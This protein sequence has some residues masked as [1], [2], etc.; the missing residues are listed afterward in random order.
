MAQRWQSPSGENIT[1]PDGF[2][3][4]GWQ[5]IGSSSAV[6]PS[7]YSDGLELWENARTGARTI[8][9]EGIESIFGKD[10][11]RI[12]PFGAPS[13]SGVK[14]PAAPTAAQPTSA[15][16]AGSLPPPGV[17]PGA[18][19]ANGDGAAVPRPLS[20]AAARARGAAATV[21]ALSWILMFLGIVVGIVVAIQKEVSFATDETTH[22]YVGT[23]IAIIVVSIFQACTLIMIS[24]YIQFRVTE[25]SARN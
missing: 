22:P 24:A 8:G 6:E 15:P 7:R 1:I 10:W 18:S 16:S 21:E 4:S 19:G 25:S 12:G 3:P 11:R 20:P 5:R 13:P 17:S 9:F 14:A 23:G 2:E